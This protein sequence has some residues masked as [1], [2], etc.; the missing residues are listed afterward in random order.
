M[1]WRFVRRSA[2]T[3]DCSWPVL[4][5]SAWMSTSMSLDVG[6]DQA[7]RSSD[8]E[9]DQGRVEPHDRCWSFCDHGI[10]GV[11]ENFLEAVLVDP[12]A[13]INNA[14]SMTSREQY[15]DRVCAG[16]FPMALQREGSSRARWFDDYVRRASSV[17]SRSL[18]RVCVRRRCCRGCWS[19]W[20]R[21]PGSCST[22]RR[23]RR[24]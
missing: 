22:S 12:L 2:R 15:I 18:R 14:L 19:D 11:Q 16:G 10:D 23:L 7:T 8:V 5:R 9:C 6:C 24:R 17:T 21:R 20:P 4:H 3:R 1:I 13:P